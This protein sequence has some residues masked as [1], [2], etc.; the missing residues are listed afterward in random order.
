M[1]ANM[2]SSYTTPLETDEFLFLIPIG[3]YG[4]KSL[5]VLMSANNKWRMALI[6]NGLNN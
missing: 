2:I 1:S 4:G 6:W 5:S 3:Y